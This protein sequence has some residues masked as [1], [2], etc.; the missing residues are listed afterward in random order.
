MRGG[1]YQRTIEL[2]ELGSLFGCIVYQH[3]LDIP[4]RQATI[5]ITTGVGRIHRSYY[6]L[7]LQQRGKQEP[8]GVHYEHNLNHKWNN[9]PLHSNGH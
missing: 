8:K 5:E 1:K 6:S 7:N 2:I 4:S 3:E 9:Q